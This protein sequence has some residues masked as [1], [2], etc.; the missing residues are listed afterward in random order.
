MTQTKTKRGRNYLTN[1][2]IN[3]KDKTPNRIQHSCKCSL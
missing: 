3:N 1:R 2:K